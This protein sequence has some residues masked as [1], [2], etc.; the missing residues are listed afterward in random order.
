[1]AYSKLNTYS[2]GTCK[3]I[4]SGGK[5][6]DVECYFTGNHLN[7]SGVHENNY[8]C[9]VRYENGKLKIKLSEE[10]YT[11]LG[12]GPTSI[13]RCPKLNSGVK[14]A[15]I[16][17]KY[18][19][20]AK[21][22][23]PTIDIK[24]TKV[25]N[26]LFRFIFDAGD[27]DFDLDEIKVDFG[28]G[29][30]ETYQNW[31][32]VPYPH[33]R[34]RA[35]LC[36]EKGCDKKT[37]EEA[38]E[39]V[40]YHG[41]RVIKP[42]LQHRYFAEHEY[43][44]PGTYKIKVIVKDSVGWE[45]TKEIT[46]NIGERIQDSDNDGISDDKDNCPYDANPDQTDTDND[47]LGDV[48]DNCPNVANPQQIDSDNDGI[49]DACDNTPLGNV[50]TC[51]D[52]CSSVG[53]RGECFR[54]DV[55]EGYYVC[56]DFDDDECLEYGKVYCSA[57]EKC[58][59]GYCT[60]KQTYSLALIATPSSIPETVGEFK[61]V[62]T[63]KA[64]TNAQNAKFRF[65]CDGSSWSFWQTENTYICTYENVS[66]GTITAKV[67]ME[68]NGAK[69]QATANII[70]TKDKAPIIEKFTASP[71]GGGWPLKVTFKG[72]YYDIES[73][74]EGTT[75]KA[76]LDFGDG[77]KIKLD[78]YAKLKGENLKDGITHY[79]YNPTNAPKTYTAKLIIE[80][81]KGNVAEKSVNITVSNECS[82][83]REVDLTK[84][85]YGGLTVDS[86]KAI[87][88][89][90]Q[91]ISWMDIRNAKLKIKY[92]NQYRSF[93][94][95][96]RSVTVGSKN[97]VLVDRKFLESIP[98]D[99]ITLLGDL[100]N[101][102]KENEVI[103]N[104]VYCV[105][106]KIKRSEID[107]VVLL[108]ETKINNIYALDEDGNPKEGCEI[109]IIDKDGNE[110]KFITDNNGKI[111][112]NMKVGDIEE[113]RSTCAYSLKLETDVGDVLFNI[114]TGVL[115]LNDIVGDGALWC[116]DSENN[117]TGCGETTFTD[118][119]GNEIKMMPDPIQGVIPLAAL[120]PGNFNVKAGGGGAGGGGGMFKLKLGALE[121]F[122]AKV[123]APLKVML[124]D[125]VEIVLLDE[126]TE[127]PIP[128]AAA[129][130]KTP[131]EEVITVKA[132]E[133]GKTI[134]K[135]NMPGIYEIRF[136]KA[137]AE[138]EV[139][140][141]AAFTKAFGIDKT[142]NTITTSLE[143]L[144]NQLIMLVLLAA[145]A[146][147]VVI[148]RL[149]DIFKEIKVLKAKELKLVRYAVTIIALLPIA[150]VSIQNNALAIIASIVEIAG[151][152]ISYFVAKLG[153]KIMK[154]KPIRV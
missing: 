121:W 18:I 17:V 90:I 47:G 19:N 9:D 40:Y 7:F 83:V 144:G 37:L 75:L 8:N 11:I 10:C 84:P 44:N 147:G 72:S 110:K 148:Y 63:L 154:Y 87:N 111:E 70:V 88:Q 24:W 54:D 30:I 141:L 78:E 33:Y 50:P 100:V 145:I 74:T 53:E 149:S 21:R 116:G 15:S 61:R 76:W 136:S 20:F 123:I 132:D 114:P 67:E 3:R 73:A 106:L 79:Y 125:E 118:Q 117:I 139:Y 52:E 92:N 108:P 80:D 104:N 89:G 13:E 45:T 99:E 85:R 86:F 58:I 152:L 95:P 146:C 137:K 142:I 34:N 150:Y 82:N 35:I 68:V 151:V 62:V 122:I 49:G 27:K 93:D 81:V 64:N 120:P 12:G 51:E 48:C 69:Q 23:H 138:F 129:K 55:G 109:T 56:G 6:C 71:I 96:S 103:G 135:P 65:S 94:I 66:P 38:Q 39:G 113:I 41:L 102:D 1:M 26:N 130:I 126:R 32:I 36:Y 25:S 97:E 119:K 101:I 115:N 57:G 60:A 131:A 140:P 124:G 112:V 107:L 22:Y 29:A 77:L 5:Y 105:R 28:D 133:T 2:G 98:E 14:W 43:T 134:Y 46:V 128:Y 153:L 42:Y 59:N 16:Q 127:K 91:D 4:C 31:P 143:T